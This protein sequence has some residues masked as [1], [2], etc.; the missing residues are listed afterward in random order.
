[1]NEKSLKK[2]SVII[3]CYNAEKYIRQ[4]LDSVA[5]QTIG[6]EALEVILVNDASADDTLSYLMQF[7]ARFPDSVIVINLE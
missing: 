1:M 4:C 5:E 6:M 7:E 3:P 2:V